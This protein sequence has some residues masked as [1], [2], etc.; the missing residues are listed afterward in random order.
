MSWF[1]LI[2]AVVASLLAYVRVARADPDKVHRAVQGAA[3]A[4]GEGHCLRVVDAGPEA[5]A[6]ADAAMQALERTRVIAGSVGEGRIT[7]ETRSKWV[8]FPDYTTIE[9]DGDT[10]KMFARLRFGRSDFGVNRAR[11]DKVLRA[12]NG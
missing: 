8:G 9:Q 5:L 1:W 3:D 2:V 4:D 11:L 7:Y 10:L 6:K 12:V